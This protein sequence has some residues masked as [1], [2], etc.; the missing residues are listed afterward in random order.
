M[1]AAFVG[2]VMVNVPLATVCAGKVNTATASLLTVTS[3][4]SHVS[5]ALEMVSPVQV[6]FAEGV[7]IATAPDTVGEFA[8]VTVWPP[9]V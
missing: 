8:F 5:N 9:A 1:P 7:Q 3:Y 6:K 2:I 4:S